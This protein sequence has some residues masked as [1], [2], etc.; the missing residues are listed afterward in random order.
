MMP[1]DKPIRLDRIIAFML[2]ALLCACATPTPYQPDIPGQRVAGGFSEERLA[3]DRYRVTFAGNCFTSRERVERYLLYRAAELTLEKD[4]DWFTVIDRLT[5]R[6]E[7]T[8]ETRVHSPH[9]YSAYGY[10]RPYWRY[11]GPSYGWRDWDPVYGGPFWAE[12]VSLHTVEQFTAHAEIAMHRG[13]VPETEA[14][15]LIARDVIAN[16]EATIERPGHEG[17]C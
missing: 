6:D 16:L 17:T 14:R 8:Y 4:Y 12:Q 9:W 1:V 3:A 2:A 10:W 7:R 11:Y 15:A 13:M 5:E